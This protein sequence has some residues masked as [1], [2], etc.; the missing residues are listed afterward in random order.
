MP[1][2]CEHAAVVVD[3]LDGCRALKE[4]GHCMLEAVQC[5]LGGSGLE[6]TAT[7]KRHIMLVAQ[8]QTKNI[9]TNINYTIKILILAFK[10]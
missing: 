8:Y 9:L 7:K 10:I 2:E 5:S 4:A 6:C 3:I 1:V